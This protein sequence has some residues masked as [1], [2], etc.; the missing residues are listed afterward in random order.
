MQLIRSG[1]IT[2]DML[3]DM[4]KSTKSKLEM[5]RNYLTWLSTEKDIKDLCMTYYYFLSLHHI[6]QKQ[7]ASVWK[8]PIE[9]TLDHNQK[10]DFKDALELLNSLTGTI[11]LK[12]S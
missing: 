8:K 1:L 6:A 5:L 12:K 4:P 3:I 11:K 10:K 9:I 2:S 7:F